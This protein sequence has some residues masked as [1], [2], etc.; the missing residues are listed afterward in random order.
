MDEIYHRIM[1][2]TVPYLRFEKDRLEH[3]G[4]GI[5][6]KIA[7]SGFVLSAFHVL[8]PV[9]DKHIPMWIGAGSQDSPGISLRGL[10]VLKANDPFDIALV[11]LRP[12]M[13]EQIACT[14]IFITLSKCDIS[15]AFD[16]R[17]LFFVCG[18]P[19]VDTLSSTARK[20]LHLAPFGIMTGRYPGD[21]S[22]FPVKAY[23]DE[24][25][26]LL[27]Y[28]EGVRR[29]ENWAPIPLPEPLGM[30]GCGVW[31][32]PSPGIPAEH[33]EC[34]DLRLAAVVQSVHTKTRTIIATRF[35]YVL[36]LL[37]QQRPDLRSSMRLSFPDFG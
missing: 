29:D 33:W 25:H 37:Y 35:K 20:S 6:M 8:S 17:Q 12:S 32:L 22:Q 9:L 34:E 23:R 15:H 27:D 10:S 30:S 18:F 21:S 14:N 28:T 36:Q 13:S 26:L 7:N 3:E 31:R 19:S 4:S 24:L 5:L 16:S 2:Y 11:E 1:S